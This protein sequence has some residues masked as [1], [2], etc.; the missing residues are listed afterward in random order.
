MGAERLRSSGCQLE[1]VDPW[2]Q[3]Y[4]LRDI[5]RLQ[6]ARI[7]RDGQIRI[8]APDRDRERTS[9]VPGRELEN[10][11]ESDDEAIR[12]RITGVELSVDRNPGERGIGEES[13]QIVR[14]SGRI[15]RVDGEGPQDAGRLTG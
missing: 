10:R 4:V 9:G 14:V 13:A 2:R 1:L 5:N 12:D 7:N 15:A 11:G 8:G 3:G 6:W